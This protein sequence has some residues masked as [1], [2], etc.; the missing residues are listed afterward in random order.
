MTPSALA[1]FLK[2]RRRLIIE[3]GP[4]ALKQP[5]KLRIR[6]QGPQVGSNLQFQI[7]VVCL[8]NICTPSPDCSLTLDTACSGSLYALRLGCRALTT[9]DCDAAI[10]AASNL[11]FG[12][13]QHIGTVRL[14]ILSATG[15]TR[16]FECICRWI[17]PCRRDRRSLYQ[18]T[19]WR[20]CSRWSY[21]GCDKSDGCQHVS[22]LLSRSCIFW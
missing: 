17:W 18:A 2:Y 21:T 13:E 15:P 16:S 22:Y 1:Y 5:N 6:S 14:G 12:I 20:D 4:D 11:V 9:G 8:A 7:K 10:V 19:S 3:Y